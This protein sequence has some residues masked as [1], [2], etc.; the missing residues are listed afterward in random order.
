MPAKLSTYEFSLFSRFIE[1]RAGIEIRENKAYL[2]ENRL[3]R[4][5]NDGNCPSFHRLY[6]DMI[7]DP[8]GSLAEKVIDAITTNETYWFRDRTPW[9]YLRQEWLPR[10]VVELRSRRRCRARIWSAAAAT[11]QEAYSMAILIDRYLKDNGITDVLLS[12]FEILATDISPDALQ[13]AR[14][15][16]YDEIAMARGLDAALRDAYFARDGNGYLLAEPIRRAVTFRHFNL[17]NSFAPLG[18][19]DVIFLRYAMIYFSEPMRQQTACKLR[20]ALREDG[21]LFLGASE[22]YPCIGSQFTAHRFGRAIF[23][24]RDKEHPD[25]HETKS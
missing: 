2:I 22:L 15:G 5:L 25:T 19:F 8:S 16:R 20:L 12:Q 7:E 24:M 9:E 11:G 1:E 6:R 14:A 4:L 17:Q 23:Y 10:I 21:V 18:S 3:L 13:R